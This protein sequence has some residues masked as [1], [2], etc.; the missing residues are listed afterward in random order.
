MTVLP[1]AGDIVA[2]GDPCSTRRRSTGRPGPQRTMVL[3]SQPA[4]APA[5]REKVLPMAALLLS[6][7]AHDEMPIT[8]I[9]AVATS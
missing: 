1:K 9:D 5:A 3:E 8:T 7:A 2:D 6:A 4:G